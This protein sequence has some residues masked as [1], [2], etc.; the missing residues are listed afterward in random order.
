MSDNKEQIIKS[1]IAKADES[2]KMAELAIENDF[3]NSAQ[4]NFIIA[5]FI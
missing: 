5:V 3:W 1:R 4:V 2:L